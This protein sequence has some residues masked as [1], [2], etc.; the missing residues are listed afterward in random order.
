MAYKKILIAVDS[1][2]YSMKAAKKGL[3]LAHQLGAKAALLFVIE[4]SKALGNVDAGITHEQALIVL[5]KEAEQTLDELAQMYNGNEL[6][7]FMPEG[8]PEEDILKT[9]QNWKA[10]LLVL[11]THGRTGLKHLLMGSVAER[12]MRHSNIP[13]MMVS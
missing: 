9:A 11:G 13:V 6:L 10:D 7:K 12:V 2:E 5:K 8:N 1:S 3:E 4:K